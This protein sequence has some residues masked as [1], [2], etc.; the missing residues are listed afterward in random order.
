MVLLFVDLFLSYAI[1]SEKED[2]DQ[3]EVVS[4]GILPGHGFYSIPVSVPTGKKT[5]SIILFL[6]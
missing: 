6:T 1:H 3:Q 5:T 2:I 4:L